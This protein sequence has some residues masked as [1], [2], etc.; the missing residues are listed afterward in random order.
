[1]RLARDRLGS[2]LGGG[3]LVCCWCAGGGDDVEAW[4]VYK[5]RKLVGGDGWGRSTKRPIPY[6][7]DLP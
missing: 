6:I 3:V 5:G 1:M 7:Y 2:S 4:C